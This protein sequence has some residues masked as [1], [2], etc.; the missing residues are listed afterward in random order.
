MRFWVHHFWIPIRYK[1]PPPPPTA[2]S[3]PVDNT[4][5]ELCSDMIDVVPAKNYRSSPPLLIKRAAL[6]T[7]DTLWSSVGRHF[8]RAVVFDMPLNTKGLLG[9][10][11]FETFFRDSR[12]GRLNGRV[13]YRRFPT[14]NLNL[15]QHMDGT[16]GAIWCPFICVFAQSSG[17]R[18]K[19]KHT[20]CIPRDSPNG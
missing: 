8:I 19:V 1:P 10:Y 11:L 18:A 13:L 4:T 3:S 2:D 6:Y 14:I 15:G 9:G 5:Y 17:A 7:W 20:V 12:G 16:R